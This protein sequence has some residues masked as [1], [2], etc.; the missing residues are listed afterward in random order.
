MHGVNYNQWKCE[1]QKHEYDGDYW[2]DD[3][4]IRFKGDNVARY[5]AGHT[6]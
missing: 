3:L 2:L 4:A 6:N 1:A 5:Y